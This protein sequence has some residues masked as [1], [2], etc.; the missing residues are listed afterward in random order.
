MKNKDCAGHDRI[1]RLIRRNL[2]EKETDKKT[3]SEP[4]PVMT[5]RPVNVDDGSTG[6]GRCIGFTSAA[7]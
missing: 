5:S 2:V 4:S 6:D 1:V 3:N 7:D